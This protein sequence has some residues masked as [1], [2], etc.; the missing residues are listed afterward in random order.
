MQ[1]QV[2]GRRRLRS[3]IG[4]PLSGLAPG[5]LAVGLERAGRTITL[6]LC[7]ELDLVTAALVR[8]AL[9]QAASER[10]DHLVIDLREL[11]FID[12][13]GVHLLL[14]A[15]RRLQQTWTSLEIRPGGRSVQ[16]I[17]QL[18]HLADF[19]PIVKD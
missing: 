8:A 14:D 10:P 5:A 12:S 9:D 17:F 11:S 6:T 15:H 2:N 7:G 1:P 19:L 18:T 13:T 16:R 3:R 4:R